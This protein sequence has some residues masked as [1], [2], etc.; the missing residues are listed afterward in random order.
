MM[1]LSL[2]AISQRRPV[3]DLP[4]ISGSGRLPLPS[5]KNARTGTPPKDTLDFKRRDDLADSINISYRF[6]NEIERYK[7]DS[8]INDF[9]AYFSVPSTWNSLGNNGSAAYPLLYQPLLKPGFDAGLHAFDLYKFTI[10]NTRIYNT[11]R[12]FSYV[13]YMLGGGKEQMVNLSHTQNPRPNLNWGLD[14]RLISSPGFFVTQNTNHNN[15]RLYGDYRSK[16]KRYGN[17]IILLGNNLRASENGGIENDSFLLDPN[18]KKRFSI[19]VNLGNSSGYS[20]NPFQTTV[21]TGNIYRNYEVLARQFYDIGR[22]DS[23]KINDSIT[24]HLFYPRLRLEHTFSYG[25]SHYRFQDVR[26][27]SA[28]Y[29]EWYNVTLPRPVDSFHLAEKWSVMKNDLSVYSFPDI[30]NQHQF[31]MAG[32]R[33]ENIKG[34]FTNGQQTFF[35]LILHGAY[36]NITRNKLW[37]INLSGE[38]YTAGLNLGDYKANASLQRTLGRK[39]GDISVNFVNVNRTPSFIYDPRSSFA[40]GNTRKFNKENTVALGAQVNNPFINLGFSNYLITNLLYYNDYRGQEQYGS[41]VNFTRFTASRSQKLTRRFVWYGEAALQLKGENVP[42]KV[43]MFYSRNRLAYEGNFY[44]NLYLSTGLELRYFTPYKMNAYSPVNG[45]FFVQDTTTI[46]NLPDVHAFFD[47][48]IKSFT[49]Y[50]RAENLNTMSFV[51]GFGFLNN[52]FA[53]PSYPTPGY[54][55]RIGIRWWFVN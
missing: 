14:Y 25:S 48:R 42:V 2:H 23:L 31:I 27:D 30:K 34:I 3:G 32:V 35:N 18:K 17:T 22:Q 49:A 29:S 7:V 33:M 52:N 40:L 41:P 6:F 5:D 53:A 15:Y 54:M 28:T 47:F 45:Q 8:S 51:D 55:L 21:Y 13:G 38:V 39:W 46:R 24:E 26:A 12:P 20:P 1:V 50:I 11:T 10:E 37:N 16:K 44:K 43:P 19:P 9:D 4:T 36:K